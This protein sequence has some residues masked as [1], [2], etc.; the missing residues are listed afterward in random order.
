MSFASVAFG[1]IEPMRFFTAVRWRSSKTVKHS[2]WPASASLIMVL[3]SNVAIDGVIGGR[4]TR[5]SDCDGVA[6]RAG[7]MAVRTHSCSRISG[8]VKFDVQVQYYVVHPEVYD[9]KWNV[10]LQVTPVIP[11][12]IK[13]YCEANWP[14][15]DSSTSGV[16]RV[17]DQVGSLSDGWL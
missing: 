13:R 2:A 3:S 17:T 9:P 1:A 10:Q 14:R 15:P 8:P 5:L 6:A 7:Q 11:S 16:H 4:P 12:L